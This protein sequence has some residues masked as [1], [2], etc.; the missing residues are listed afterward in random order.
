MFEDSPEDGRG[1]SIALLPSVDVAI[2]V[3]LRAGEVLGELRI[4]VDVHAAAPGGRNCESSL[5]CAAGAKPSKLRRA[6]PSTIACETV[7]TP[8][9]STTARSSTSSR[10]SNSGSYPKSRRNQDSF[11]S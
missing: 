6:R 11:H 7:T 10:P 1:P 8:V 4:G 9:R 2:A 3:L 5:H